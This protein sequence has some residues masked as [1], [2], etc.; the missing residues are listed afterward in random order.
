MKELK[1]FEDDLFNLVRNIEYRY[2][3]NSFQSKLTEKIKEIQA[4]DDVIVKADKTNN[5]YKIPVHKYKS[6]LLENVTKEYKK[7]NPRDVKAVNY[8]A[9]K[10]AGD[11]DI[12]QS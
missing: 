11:L 7:S 3:Q 9:A 8:E 6:L 1:P 12:E 4:T 10:I 2:I 5:L